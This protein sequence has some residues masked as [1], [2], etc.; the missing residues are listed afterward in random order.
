MKQTQMIT[1]K[2]TVVVK[3]V[4]EA[5]K[6][7]VI[8]T[9]VNA[10]EVIDVLA[11]GVPMMVAEIFRAKRSVDA[12]PERNICVRFLRLDQHLPRRRLALIYI[13]HLAIF[14]EVQRHW[15]FWNHARVCEVLGN[16]IQT[17]QQKCI[18]YVAV[19][20]KCELNLE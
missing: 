7:I 19:L 1:I 10:V 8:V 2:A 11:A 4:M 14:V 20:W 18:N 16:E 3:V 9:D 12:N 13:F 5:A 17:T 15:F 6:V